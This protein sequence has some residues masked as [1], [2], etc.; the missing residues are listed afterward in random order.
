MLINKKSSQVKCNEIGHAKLSEKSDFFHKIPA[1]KK[2]SLLKKQLFR[3][4][5]CLEIVHILNNYLFWRKNSYEMVAVLKK[6]LPSRSKEVRSIRKKQLLKTTR[7][8]IKKNLCKKSSCFRR[9]LLFNYNR[10][11]SRNIAATITTL[12]HGDW[13]FEKP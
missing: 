12:F 5:A 3:I 1:P 8:T 9:L 2:V 6:C 10:Y 11:Y 13:C 4:S 7:Y